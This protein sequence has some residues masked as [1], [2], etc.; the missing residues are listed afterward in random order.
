LTVTHTAVSV[1]RLVVEARGVVVILA[2]ATPPVPICVE[3]FRLV[4][5][6]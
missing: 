2:S 3:K 1:G 4:L 5:M 6:K